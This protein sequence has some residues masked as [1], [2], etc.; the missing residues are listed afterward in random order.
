MRA[1]PRTNWQRAKVAS[2][3][4]FRRHT[5]MHREIPV[6]VQCSHWLG[7]SEMPDVYRAMRIVGGRLVMVS[8]HR[9]LSAAIKA[10]EG[11]R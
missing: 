9:K 11:L 6:A 5:W 8:R 1:P 7:E 4:D 3:G 2:D 10:A